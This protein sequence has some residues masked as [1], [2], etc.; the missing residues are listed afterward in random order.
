MDNTHLKDRVQ[1]ESV[2]WKDHL[3]VGQAYNIRQ[4]VDMVLHDKVETI[5]I[6]FKFTYNGI[7]SQNETSNR[8]AR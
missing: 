8:Y 1:I 4:R 5:D 6:S 2:N 7:T 3:V